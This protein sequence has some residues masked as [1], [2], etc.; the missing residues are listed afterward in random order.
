M[1]NIFKNRPTDIKGIR[2]A[3]LQV[4]KE[5]LQK[6]EGGEGGSIKAIQLFVTCAADQKHLYESAL[7]AEQENR[8]KTDE[9]QRIAD[10]YAIELPN[11]WRLEII[12]TDSIP[13]E[14]RPASNIDM[15]VCI[16]TNNQKAAHKEFKA[17]IK[18]LNG[19]TFKPYYEINAQMA[20]V[21]IGREEQVQTA[22]GFYRKNHV[23]FVGDS[24]SNANRSVSRQHAH[25]EWNAEQ[26]AYYLFA[27]E[28]GLPPH[29]K[30]KVR[31]NDG[32]PWKLQTTE[33]GYKL[34][35]GDQVILGESAVIEF[36]LK[37]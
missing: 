11:D 23:A 5:Q 21:N 3:M 33:V 28:G 37:L 27:D 16:V 32:E 22:E 14:A 12:Y 4:I 7:Y 25:I 18:A 19:D 20:R 10:D 29:N 1:L 15:A 9:I 35:D 13:A 17:F 31:S 34:Q 26:G 6:A 2:H 30:I 36:S 8:F 24:P